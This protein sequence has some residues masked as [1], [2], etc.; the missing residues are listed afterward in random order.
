MKKKILFILSLTIVLSCSNE[1][2]QKTIES[3]IATHNNHDIEKTMEFYDESI[4]FELKGVWTKKGKRDIRALEEWDAALNSHLKL[5][6]INSKEDT[7]FCKVIENNDWFRGVGITN[8]VHD[9][10]IFV[11]SNGKIKNIIGYPSEKTGKEIGTAIGKLYQ[12]SQKNQDSTINE[13]IINGQFIYSAQAAE[14]WLT[15]FEKIGNN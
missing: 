11:V 13:L 7:I 2:H 10:A 9:P 8:L 3:Y 14:K 1:T 15:L 5:E 12:W 6:S 4:I